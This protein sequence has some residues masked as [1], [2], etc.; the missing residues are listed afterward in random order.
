M[1]SH[2]KRVLLKYCVLIVKMYGDMLAKPVIK[3]AT[4]NYHR[5]IDVRTLLLLATLIPFFKSVKN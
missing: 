4:T 3:D 1:L 5:L 2:L